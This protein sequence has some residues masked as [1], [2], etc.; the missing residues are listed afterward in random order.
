MSHAT[1]PM[2]A[3]QP[4]GSVLVSASAS[5]SMSIRMVP[6]TASEGPA[7]PIVNVASCQVP[8]PVAAGSRGTTV[9]PVIDTSARAVTTVFAS[10]T[11]FSG[12]GSK[13]LGSFTTSASL[14]IVD[15]SG[16]SWATWTVIWN[17]CVWPA[18]MP[19]GVLQVTSC[20][21]AVAAAATHQTGVTEPGPGG[22][23]VTPGGSASRRVG[24]SAVTDSGG[25]AM[26]VMSNVSTMV[27]PAM[28]VA[29]AD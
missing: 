19:L 15:P 5:D 4:G 14:V 3:T 18:T 11:L 9:S 22:T 21:S 6:L 28:T 20:P 2:E 13:S 7:L 12:D 10:A 16:T 29:G 26:L 8:A 17:D 1:S 25:V 24:G 27:S 23:S